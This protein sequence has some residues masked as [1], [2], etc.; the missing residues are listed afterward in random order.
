MPSK[1]PPKVWLGDDG[2]LRIDYG[3]HPKIDLDAIQ[4][5]YAQ[6]IAIST[7]PRPIMVLGEGAVT[8]TPEAEAFSNTAEVRAVTTAVALVTGASVIGRLLAQLFLSYRHP[9]YPCKI[10]E[11]Q[12]AAVEWLRQY[13]SEESR[14]R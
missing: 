4:S 1:R 10:F 3:Q 13:A 6:H 11:S 2:I 14:G 9:K 8:A 12:A 7:E 5:A